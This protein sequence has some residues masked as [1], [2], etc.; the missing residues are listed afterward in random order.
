MM[1]GLLIAALLPALLPAPKEM[2]CTAGEF[3]VRAKEVT[4]ALVTF[5]EDAAQPAEGY[6][7]SVTPSGVKVRASSEAGRFYAVETLKQ[8]GARM[9]EEIVFPCVE[10]ADAPAY[11]YRGLMIDDSRHFFGKDAISVSSTRWRP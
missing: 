2:T 5:A 4:T 11:R 3:A 8:L 7:L 1:N 6:A 10:I 9:G